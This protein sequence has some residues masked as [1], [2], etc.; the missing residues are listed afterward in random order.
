MEGKRTPEQLVSDLE[1]CTGPCGNLCLSCP[2]SYELAEIHDIIQEL[3]E[4]RDR[5]KEMAKQIS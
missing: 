4:E 1:N 5:Y 2:E 3:I